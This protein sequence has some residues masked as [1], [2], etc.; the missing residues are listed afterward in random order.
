MTWKEKLLQYSNFA[1]FLCVLDC[2]IL[3]A[4]TILFPLVGIVA[5]PASLEWLH[6]AGHQLA[7]Y[8]VMPVGFTA[9]TTNYLYNH[10]TAWITALG[11]LGLALVFV[12]NAHLHLHGAP[13]LVTKFL[14][15]VHHGV[16][17]RVANLCG[18]ALLI[19]SNYIS[20]R[21]G[22]CGDPNCGHDHHH[23]H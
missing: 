21:R 7:L 13:A 1:S 4:V 16:A 22:G 8:F 6:H 12:S 10:K 3:P 9:T 17:H 14:H 11:W 5:A 20:R 18:C 23:S 19:T 2:T 15:L